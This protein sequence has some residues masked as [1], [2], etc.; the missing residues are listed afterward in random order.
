MGI[1]DY[2]IVKHVH[3]NLLGLFVHPYNHIEMSSPPH[4]VRKLLVS[5]DSEHKLF[6]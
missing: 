3:A 6:A 1:H 2:I 5:K 4:F